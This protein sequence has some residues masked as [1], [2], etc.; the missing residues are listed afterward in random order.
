MGR[1]VLELG[2]HWVLVKGGHA[3]LT[4]DYKVAG[5]EDEKSIVVDVL[6]GRGGVVERIESAY[7]RST[8][9][10]GTGCSLASAIASNL[11]K[12]LDVPEA[13]KKACRYIEGAIRTAPGFGQGHGPL[14][15]FHSNYSLPFAPGRFI[16]YLLGRP[17]V[18]DVWKTFVYHPFVMGLGNGTL[19][20]ASFKGYLVQDYLY[21]VHFARANALA[22]YK[23]TSM[24]D[25]VAGATI[26]KHIATEMALHIDYCAGFGISV[27]QIEATE[28]HQACTAYTRYVL[29]VGMSG[30][31][32]GLQVALAPCLLGYGAVAKQLHGDAASVRGEGNVYWKWI[33]NYIAEDYQQALRTGSELLERHAARQSPEGIER[34]AKIFIHGTKVRV[35]SVTGALLVPYDDDDDADDLQM[36]IGFW[37]M[38][39]CQ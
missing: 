18:R 34:L 2:P 31:W 8:N 10:H 6:V 3:P 36:E 22:S 32:I 5:T 29:D 33:E 35:D 39:P 26:V 27:P 1:A 21:L 14:N 16:D 28:E 7:Q 30:D 15:H 19:P 17:D 24:E 20:L 12:G 4:K 13:A 25:I 37:E 23:A 38:F 11:A 9:T